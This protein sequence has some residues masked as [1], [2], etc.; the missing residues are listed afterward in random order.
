MKALVLKEKNSLAI[1]DLDFEEP[2]GPD[3]VR[4]KI[5][6]VGICGSDIHYFQHGKIGNFVV[7]NRWCWGMRLRNG[8]RDREECHESEGRE[9]GYAWNPAY[10]TCAAERRWRESTTSILPS[11]SGQHL[12]YMAVSGDRGA[13]GNVRLQAA[14]ECQLRRRGDGRTT[15]GGAPSSAES[16]YQAGRYRLGQWLRHDRIGNWAG[17]AGRRLQ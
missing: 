7:R 6:T 1:L 3:D 4:I 14:G 10:P 16:K 8:N 5:H 17:S 2:L 11:D 12:R 9:I 15:L 13:S